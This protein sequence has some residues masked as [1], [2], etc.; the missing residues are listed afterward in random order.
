M[1]N[2]A[3][4]GVLVVSLIVLIMVLRLSFRLSSQINLINQQFNAQ[5][6]D[7]MQLLRETYNNTTNVVTNV[8]SKLG[9]L[10]KSSQMIL[11]VGKNI[12]S[13][14]ELL[15]APKF[16]GQMGETMLENILS[17][18]LPKEHFKMQYRFKNNEI[19]D[20]VI[21]LGDNLVPVDAKFPLENFKRVLEITDEAQKKQHVKL[22]IRDV[23]KRIDEIAL[24]YILPDEKTYDFALM[25][26]PA[27]NIYYET[28]VKE[29]EIMSYGISKKVIP[30]SP[31][32]FYAY[33]QV[34]CL[35]LK[36]MQIEKN[37]KEVIANLA[38]LTLDMQRFRERFDLVGAHLN[39]AKTKY[40]ESQVRLVKFSDKLSISSQAKT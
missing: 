33:L 13:L 40:E 1:L 32:T 22:F 29:N 20:A 39:N 37:A 28:V 25:Y 14:G 8:Y 24:K 30:V 19:V 16:R 2:W 11:D 26:I 5:L 34:I 31:N 21:L 38:G 10:S 7:N 4:V 6:K 35:G 18:V 12:S 36:G 23:K 15:R 27:E 17:Q 9:E 3:V